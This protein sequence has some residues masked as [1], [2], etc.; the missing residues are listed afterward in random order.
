MTDQH[1]PHVVGCYGNEIVRTPNIDRLAAEGRR[2]TQ[3]YCPA[4]LCVPS[5]MSFM[6]GRLPYRNRVWAN[7]HILSS[8]IPTWAHALGAAGYETA[9][10]GKMH[11]VGSDHRHGF[12]R[13][14][15]GNFIAKHPGTPEL[16]GPRWTRF[17]GATSGQS[18]VS[19]ETVGTG[20]T[21]YQWFDRR[22]ADAAIGYLREAGRTQRTGGAQAPGNAGEAGDTRQNVAA[23]PFAAVV[24][25]NLPHCPFIAPKDL[26]DDYFDRVDVP[27]DERSA[28][29]IVKRYRRRRGIEQPPIP[30]L[31]IRRVRAAY[32]ALVEHVDRLIGEVLTALEGA[33]LADD[34]LVIYCS[35]H[36]EM[37]GEHGCYWKS[38]Y[39]EASA[40]VPLL[41]RVPSGLFPAEAPETVEARRGLP[42]GASRYRAAGT[43]ESSIVNLLDLAPTICEAADT[44]LPDLDGESILGGILGRPRSASS[45]TSELYDAKG[46]PPAILSRM[47]RRGEWKLWADFDGEGLPPVLFN[48]DA[49]PLESKDLGSDPGYAKIRNDLLAELS[50]GWNP[51]R[52]RSEAEEASRAYDAIA[53]YGQAVHPTCAQTLRLPGPDLEADVEIL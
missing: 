33:G 48:L 31:Q 24:G 43:T 41:L 3:A 49:D 51:E 39:Y 17:P 35:D 9:L 15:L 30:L 19:V 14:L 13:R 45:T 40:R 11:F 44:A 46:G 27:D 28:P 16:G 32:F 2:F 23:R 42:P 7:T 50:D 37:A 53:A 22:V 47:I 12:E 20:T 21:T 4:P 25:F 18:R 1:S 5:R 6:T 8:G 29:P 52:V 36:G 26:F 38:T 10:M 34:T